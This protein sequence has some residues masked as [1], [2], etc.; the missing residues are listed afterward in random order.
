MSSTD[1]DVHVL[2]TFYSRGGLTERLAVLLA[3]GAIQGGAMIRLRRA[4]DTEPEDVI[5]GVPR[6]RENRDRMHAEYAEPQ[7]ADADWADAIAFGTPATVYGVSRELDAYLQQIE[8]AGHSVKR[9]A[10]IASTFTSTYVPGRAREAAEEGL[11]SLLLK[12]G[13]VVAPAV[14][15]G[16][17]EDHESARAHGRRLARMARAMRTLRE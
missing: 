15:T 2:V 14:R 1:E 5:A 3:E 17:D 9:A 13:Y 12:M 8:S 6:W 16:P 4:R 7:L 11:Q 10:T